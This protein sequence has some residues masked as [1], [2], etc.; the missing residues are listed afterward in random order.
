M[1]LWLLKGRDMAKTHTGLTLNMSL[2]Y[3]KLLIIDASGTEKGLCLKKYYCVFQDFVSEFS[4]LCPRSKQ[5]L[6]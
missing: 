5:P 4:C 1:A 6:R 2:S 3:L